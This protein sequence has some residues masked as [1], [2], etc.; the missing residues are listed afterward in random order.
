VILRRSKRSCD[1]HTQYHNIKQLAI[2]NAWLGCFHT[3]ARTLASPW[4]EL[5][6]RKI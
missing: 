2:T 1:W 3:S 5:G 6:R 4:A